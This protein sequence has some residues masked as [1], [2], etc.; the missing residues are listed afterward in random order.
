MSE[1]F[2]ESGDFDDFYFE[3]RIKTEVARLKMHEIDRRFV[4]T[5]LNRI[6]A[7]VKISDRAVLDVGCADGKFLRGFK[8][9][10]NSWGIEPNK[11]QQ[12]SA[13]ANGLQI[14]SKVSQVPGLDTVILRGV[15]HHLPDYRNTIHEISEAFVNSSSK[16]RKVLFLLANP[17]A[18]SIIYRSF[19]RLPAL[20]FG[21]GFN[22]VYKVHS[23][24]GIVTELESLGFNCGIRYPYLNTPYSC[25]SKDFYRFA[26]SIAS[27]KYIETPFPRNMFNLVAT[28]QD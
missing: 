14:V 19:Q 7:K 22:S 6:Q 13:N 15:L 21:Q 12:K 3:A 28:F 4:R 18:D 16:N 27:R 20:E 24:K 1:D 2:Y 17:N 8:M 11:G 23:A 9:N 5:Q 10:G 26:T 25:V